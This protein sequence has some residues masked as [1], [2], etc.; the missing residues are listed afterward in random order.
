MNFSKYFLITFLSILLLSG[1]ISKAQSLKSFPVQ[2]MLQ[3][4]MERLGTL[5]DS[6]FKRSDNLINGRLYY[7]KGDLINHPYFVEN[8]WLSGKMWLSGRT[9][10]SLMLK[11]DI[12]TDNLINVFITD[13]AALPVEIN[14]N[15]VRE[16]MI[17]G[18]HFI[19]IDGTEVNEN[20]KF[21]PGYYE[22]LYI[23]KT[24]LYAKYRKIL[25]RNKNTLSDEYLPDVTLYIK[26]GEELIRIKNKKA[27]INLLSDRED[28][29]R[30]FVKAND[31][32][33]SF[34]NFK[35]FIR[36]LEYFDSL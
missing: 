20:R 8:G 35:S 27:F 1:E 33:F 36:V 4:Q 28:E 23:G 26:R 3:L 12:C 21:S 29:V 32:R 24:V 16:F 30:S 13:S 17:S 11:Y 34:K 14:R 22:L 2:E 5:N 7:N 6:L 31:I 25:T 18:H 15:V 19:F 10:E 9:Y